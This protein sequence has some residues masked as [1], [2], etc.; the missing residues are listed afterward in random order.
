MALFLRAVNLPFYV[1]QNK[2]AISVKLS[3]DLEVGAGGCRSIV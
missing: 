3:S 1:Y 2:P